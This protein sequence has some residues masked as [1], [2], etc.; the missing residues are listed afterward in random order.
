MTNPRLDPDTGTGP[1]HVPLEDLCETLLSGPHREAREGVARL[2]G[3][4]ATIPAGPGGG[5]QRVT[6][7]LETLAQLLESHAAKEEHILFPAVKALAEAERSGQT[8]PGLPFPTL[9]HPI[10]LLEAEHVRLGQALERLDAAV[11]AVAPAGWAH[12][13]AL[14][15]DADALAD[16]I[17]TQVRVESLALFPRALDLDRRL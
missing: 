16:A 9:L 3:L 14:R 17:A 6:E 13:A 15:R 1:L 10:R 4:A 2:R 12:W 11:N 8:R 5:A 7:A